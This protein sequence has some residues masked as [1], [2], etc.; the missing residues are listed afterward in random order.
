MDKE[1]TSVVRTLAR[2]LTE[3]IEAGETPTI[4]DHWIPDPLWEYSPYVCQ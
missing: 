2:I 1:K 3:K 4:S